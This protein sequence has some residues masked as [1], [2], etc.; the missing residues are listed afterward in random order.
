MAALR[1]TVL[2]GSELRIQFGKSV[3]LPPQ[4]IYPPPAHVQALRARVVGAVSQRGAGEHQWAKGSSAEEQAHT[5]R[6]E[7]WAWLGTISPAMLALLL[8]RGQR[9]LQ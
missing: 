1:D 9:L 6:P 5:V 4:P 3:A 2:H 7:L 8:L